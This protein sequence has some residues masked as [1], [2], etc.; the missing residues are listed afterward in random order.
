M[1]MIFHLN[2]P[3]QS[4]LLNEQ[5]RPT[6]IS[7][8][9]LPI[10]TINSLQHMLNAKYPM[11]MTFHGSPGIGKTTAARILCSVG[12]FYIVNGST[13]S[14]DKTAFRNL[15]DYAMSPTLFETLKLFII[16]EADHM[17]RSVQDKLRFLIENSSAT[18]RFI[19][20]AN[21]ITKIS[22]PIKSRCMPINFDVPVRDR[23]DVI[24]RMC[25]RYKSRLHELNIDI[26]PKRIE[27]I[28]SIYFPDLRTIA[29]IIQFECY[30]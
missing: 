9:N 22:D 16:D 12:D 11:N 8:L 30:K 6:S 15:R 18:S 25:H 20:T 19:L 21:D 1:S 2:A 10:A 14:D 27:E 23:R 26:D 5:L 3:D 7:E 17:S 28:C 13:L 29:N 24:D 4:S